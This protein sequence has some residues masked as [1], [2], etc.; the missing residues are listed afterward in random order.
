[1]AESGAICIVFDEVPNPGHGGGGVTALAV[2]SSIVALGYR[3]T[4]V[5][6]GPGFQSQI[7]IN[8]RLGHLKSI[9]AE[10]VVLD[11]PGVATNSYFLGRPLLFGRLLRILGF[12]S[13]WF[14][15]FA[16]ASELA[17]V[18]RDIDPAAVFAYHWNPLAALEDFVSAPIFGMVGDPAHLPMLFRSSQHVTPEKKLSSREKV[19]VA[20]QRVLLVPKLK[21]LQRRMLEQCARSGAFAAH[22][23]QEFRDQGLDCTYFRTPIPRP[24]LQRLRPK[25]PRTFRILLIGHL[26][27][28]A[29]LAGLRLFAAETLP[30]LH[31]LF[32]AGSFEVHVVGGFV[33]SLPD[34]LRSQLIRGGVEFRGQI[35]PA[36]EE[37]FRSDVVLVPTPITLGI[38]V[39]ILVALAHDC[40]VIAHTANGAGIPELAHNSNCLL[41]RDGLELA[42][43]CR[44]VFVSPL[45]AE[46]L[47]KGGRRTFESYF[48]VE[49]AGAKIA[50]ALVE[51]SRR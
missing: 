16:Q 15:G 33:D 6:L 24:S 27:G 20:Y 38:R 4:V 47:S 28:T 21:R 40:V 11:G 29:T 36:D 1:M 45:L 49:T 41:A 10:G 42:E 2:V 22:H 12:R 34:D 37:F 35:D 26:R 50:R 44:K 51:M 30:R 14:P 3:V 46:K 8:E 39:R 5:A 18:L 13:A 48:S 25:K 43:M 32:D 23:A 7:Q 31:E 19:R 17:E 9:G